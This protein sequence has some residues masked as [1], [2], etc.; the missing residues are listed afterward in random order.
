M[1]ISILHSRLRPAARAW[2]SSVCLAFLL[3]GCS[4]G[5]GGTGLS[6]GSG[7]PTGGGS[8]G[9]GG[10]GGGGG[11]VPTPEPEC[12]GGNFDGVFTLAAG[13][14]AD[15]TAFAAT[16]VRGTAVSAAGGGST[17]TVTGSLCHPTATSNR[18]M[19]LKLNG[20]V[21]AGTT[22]TLA[23]GSVGSHNGLQY[24]ESTTAAGVTTDK[25]WTAASGT[26]TILSVTG[27]TVTF[28][29]QNAAMAADPDFFTSNATG[30]FTL[31]VTGTVT[32][33]G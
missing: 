30:T 5:S 13:A 1:Q 8:G 14:N 20:A 32:A 2:L 17:V 11:T 23:P 10:G 3:A 9:S 21:A 28:K 18:T 15:S 19:V 22:V 4:A 24:L 25:S 33:L 6:L 29:V 7:L 12:G 26:A 16:K 31:N 27:S